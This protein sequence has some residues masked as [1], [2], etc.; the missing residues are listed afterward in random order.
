M[1]DVAHAPIPFHYSGPGN[2]FSSVAADSEPG[3]YRYEI[4]HCPDGVA[5]PTPPSYGNRHGD[6]SFL[7]HPQEST[8]GIRCFQGLKGYRG[9]GGGLSLDEPEVGSVSRFAYRVSRIGALT[10]Y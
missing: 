10:I 1:L 9:I 6:F 4:K 2:L 5:E 8:T 3:R 7:K